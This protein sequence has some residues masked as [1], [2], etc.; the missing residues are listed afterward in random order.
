MLYFCTYHLLKNS[1][2]GCDS[3]ERSE[4][5]ENKS[6]KDELKDKNNDRRISHFMIILVKKNNIRRIKRTYYKKKIHYKFL[7]MSKK[8][9][10]D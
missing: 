10:L 9:K 2:I 7:V 8:I 5:Y 6:R 3:F 4:P 1:N